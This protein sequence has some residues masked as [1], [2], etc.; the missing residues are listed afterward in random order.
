LGHNV[1][2]LQDRHPAADQRGQRPG[3]SEW[4]L[5]KA[6][7]SIPE[8]L[9]LQSSGFG[10]LRGASQQGNGKTLGFLAVRKLPPQKRSLGRKTG[11]KRPLLLGLN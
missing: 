5:V 8:Q 6:Y 7:I 2:H 4:R 3:K 10:A 9:T 1:Q 11:A